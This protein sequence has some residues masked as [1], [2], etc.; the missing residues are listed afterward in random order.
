MTDH[1]HWF[2]YNEMTE[3]EKFVKDTLG[4][5]KSNRVYT[6]ILPTIEDYCS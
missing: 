3:E 4:R 1:G 6:F 2:F 5:P